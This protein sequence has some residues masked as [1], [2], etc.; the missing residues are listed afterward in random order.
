MIPRDPVRA[1]VG[2]GF[3]VLSGV[4]LWLF[5]GADPVRCDIAETAPPAARPPA[6]DGMEPPPGVEAGRWEA[7][8]AHFIADEYVV[9]C[10]PWS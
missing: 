8:S 7:V 5:T 4:S 3:A 10:E 9:A 2:A 1:A 6:P